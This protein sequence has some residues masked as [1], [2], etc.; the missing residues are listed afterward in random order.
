VSS[1]TKME[2]TGR[3]ALQTSSI[4]R[5]RRARRRMPIASKLRPS[6]LSRDRGRPQPATPPVAI[7]GRTSIIITT[8]LAFGE[9]PRV[10]SDAKMTTAPSIAHHCD[11]VETGNDITS[12]SAVLGFTISIAETQPTLANR[13]IARAS[14]SVEMRILYH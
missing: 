9:W 4:E 11:I 7:A 6:W 1:S 12:R 14:P 10:F 5:P 8:N 13:E 3:S 2:R